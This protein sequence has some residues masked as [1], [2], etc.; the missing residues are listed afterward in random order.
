MSEPQAS[1]IPIREPL[2]SICVPVYNEEESL[3]LL[4]EAICKVIDPQKISTEIILVDDGSK[5][6]SWKV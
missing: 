6:N 4:H 5:D 3:P 1:R 2:L